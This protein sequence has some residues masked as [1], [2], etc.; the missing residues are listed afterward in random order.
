MIKSNQKGYLSLC[1]ACSWLLVSPGITQNVPTDASVLDAMERLIKEAPGAQFFTLGTSINRAYGVPLAFGASPEQTAQ[2][3]LSRYSDLF[4]GGASDYLLEG[5]YPVMRGDFT[6]L[7]YQQMLNGLPVDNGYVTLITRNSADF[8]LVLVGSNAQRIFNSVDSKPELPAKVAVT[9]AEKLNPNLKEFS[10]P[11][12]VVYMD[13]AEAKLAWVFYGDNLNMAEPERYKVFIDAR[14]GMP[15][16][17]RNEVY[18]IDVQGRVQGY[19]TPGLLPDQPNNPTVITPL[20]GIQVN[21]VGGGS[22]FADLDGYFTLPFSGTSNVTVNT[23]LRGRWVRVVDQIGNNL[24]LQQT[25]T[26]PGP[27]NFLFNT[28]RT[29]FSNAQVNG[30]LKTLEVH[31]FVKSINPNFPG[32]DIQIPCNV[33]LANTCNAYYSNSTINF[34]RAGGGC[35]NTAFSTVVQHE[36][37][38]FVISRGHP[39]AAGDYHEGVA[40]VTA[41]FLA[42]DPCLGRDFRGQNT[43]CLRNAI[44]STVYPC[45]G[46]V[47]AC[48][49]VISGAF[50][51]TYTEMKNRYPSD[52]AFA[53]DKVRQWYLNSILAR[54][55]GINP[56]I[57]I[58]V[59]TLDDNDGNLNNGS[60][61]YPQIN[62]GF[63]RHNLPAPP[64]DFL[65]LSP[66]T[67]PTAFV[68]P[69]SDKLRSRPGS[70]PDA[71][72]FEMQVTN[73]AGTLD[74]SRVYLR[75]SLNSGAFQS[76]TMTP[77][78]NNLFRAQLPRPACGAS[79]RYFFEAMDTDNRATRY[80]R[81]NE[82]FLQFAVGSNL[83]TVFTDT[84]ETN[85]GWTVQNTSLTA[86]A[87]TRTAPRG[88]SL[89]GQPA[90]P[91]ADSDDA[92]TQCFFTGQGSVGG[93]VGEADVDG[94][95]TTLISP[96][97]DLSGSNA[98]IEYSRWYYNDDGDDPFIVEV[99]NN[100]GATWVRVESRLFSA[101]MNSWNRVSF[102]VGDY[103]TPTNQ[104]RVRFQAIDNPNNSITE[105]AIDNFMVK[106]FS[107]G[108]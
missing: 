103:V 74:P 45:S 5:A 107:C 65:N 104:V 38:H 19:A 44:N 76:M 53:L 63:T 85:L 96:L 55:S 40:D 28:E 31:D 27:A 64:I 2:N 39:S 75:Y 22:V 60:P 58:D 59:L 89:N 4:Q 16:E 32:V 37:G 70:L 88:T 41:A 82:T 10:E 13:E 100:N 67:T 77:M 102:V 108:N 91:G 62:T 98:V 43:G 81:T 57:T 78:G 106:K 12:L 24:T 90:N 18:H 86:G 101:G 47:H 29:E 69:P 61:H 1:L 25:V 51:Q 105:A 93:A 42:D 34:Y 54:P 6:V 68:D 56:A 72:V 92:G 15:L 87:W 94:G 46:G 50:W 71:V 99:S 36:Y 95:P 79:A 33:N 26:P 3:F 23:D 17:W 14:T 20:G 83:E 7:Q 30:Y 9:I 11:E 66:V 97:F 48:G 52:H 80:P 73:N 84:F 35:P 21:L 8:P 49:Q